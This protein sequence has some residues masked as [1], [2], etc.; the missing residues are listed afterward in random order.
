MR[1]LTLLPWILPL[2]LLRLQIGVFP[3]T[4]LEL[5][6]FFL[7][8]SFTW[9]R[10][11]KA[12]REGFD[13][14]GPWRW[15][16]AAWLAVTLGEAFLSPSLRTGLGLWRAY[17]LEPLFVFV[18]MTATIKTE[19]D[20]DK[21]RRAFF[22]VTIV[23]AIWAIAQFAT[24]WGIPHPWNVAI[25]A[26][27]RATGPFP[28][29]NALALFVGPIGI[30]ALGGM[31]KVR[32]QKPEVLGTCTWVAALVAIMLAKSDGGLAAFTSVAALLLLMERRTRRWTIAALIVTIGVVIAT[33]QLRQPLWRE[34]SFQGWSG[35]VRLYIWRD[36][37][38]MLKDHPLTG[39]GFGGYPTLFK[40]YQ[41]TRGIE[42]F[43]YPHNIVLNV[44]SE[45]GLVGLL[46]FAWI[47]STWIHGAF[48]VPS[49]TFRFS[50]FAPLLVILLHGLVDVP[51]FKND[52]AME[53]WM[54]A[55]LM[56][57]SIGRVELR[58]RLV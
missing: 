48:R 7:F 52:L 19:E 16:V 43:Q 58:R 30:W 3:T 24:G 42:V 49:S 32:S 25:V 35:K 29:P 21:I 8:V 26:G 57:F 39:A 9:R 46:I 4:L 41:R 54:L 37:I 14:L 50:R 13:R 15:P 17:V 53:F 11:W 18:I 28:Y 47:V 34:A 12:W 10:G 20:V 31:L 33:P 2:Y 5:F 6:V 40:S 22:G 45:A 56:T 38:T 1:A 23:L 51:Y 36:T 55:W 27:R 44:W